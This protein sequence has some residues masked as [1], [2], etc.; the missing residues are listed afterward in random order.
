MSMADRR[1]GTARIIPYTAAPSSPTSLYKMTNNTILE[2]LW[3][4]R[5]YDTYISYADQALP[6][7][8]SDL[9]SVS[10]PCN[11]FIQVLRQHINACDYMGIR[12]LLN[13]AISEAIMPLPE[14]LIKEMNEMISTQ[15]NSG[16]FANNL[17]EQEYEFE[18]MVLFFWESLVDLQLGVSLTSLSFPQLKSPTV[19]MGLSIINFTLSF[20][21]NELILPFMWLLL[22]SDVENVSIDKNSACT[23][24]SIP[25]ASNLFF[26]T[27]LALNA[28]SL[29]RDV[30]KAEKIILI[31]ML[32]K[33]G[34]N[35]FLP[36]KKRHL[37]RGVNKIWDEITSFYLYTLCDKRNAKYAS[38]FL[39]SHRS[40]H[41][42]EFICFPL[43]EF[44]ALS[45]ISCRLMRESMSCAFCHLP[46]A[47]LYLVQLLSL[48]GMEGI[49]REII[50]FLYLNA[51]ETICSNSDLTPDNSLKINFD[52]LIV[53][54]FADPSML[55]TSK[56]FFSQVVMTESLES[57]TIKALLN[58]ADIP[59]SRKTIKSLIEQSCTEKNLLYKISDEKLHGLVYKIVRTPLCETFL[60]KLGVYIEDK[61]SIGPDQVD[62][63]IEF[64]ILEPHEFPLTWREISKSI[65]SLVREDCFPRFDFKVILLFYF[66]VILGNKSQ[67]VLTPVHHLVTL[68]DS[69][70]KLECPST[71]VK[72]GQ[73]FSLLL[74]EN[75]DLLSCRE[76]HRV[77]R[78]AGHF[79]A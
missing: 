48:H 74:T 51:L 35:S 69:L 1:S 60:R 57:S 16:H 39:S 41:A 70:Q 66:K 63:S 24:E 36:E 44:H 52:S 65:C 68:T 59:S 30:I 47:F 53:S 49:S 75:E 76:V 27:R 78:N 13:I 12:N 42:H 29:V 19:T 34:A 9:I 40:R 14:S 38:N 8:V 6:Y 61:S 43:T 45:D 21:R 73:F 71:S 25:N 26:T 67:I 64:V 7:L 79:T 4:P 15:R 77:S 20:P 31:L 23:L 5:V 2:R 28:A 62:F 46:N 3:T 22:P 58:H 54:L 50:R 37:I 56:S 10:L 11:R 32:S 55:L 33:V 17:R 18:Q 72:L